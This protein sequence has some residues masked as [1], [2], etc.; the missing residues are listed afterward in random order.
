MEKVDLKDS[1]QYYCI[2]SL[3]QFTDKRS[4]LGWP[5]KIKTKMHFPYKTQW[6]A[7][8][9]FDYGVEPFLRWECNLQF[10]KT[11]KSRYLFPHV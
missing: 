11:L 1:H 3:H 4:I 8:H 6:Y 2:S 7:S 9:R 10:I 5:T